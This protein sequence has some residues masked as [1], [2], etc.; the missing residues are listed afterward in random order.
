MDGGTTKT[1]KM[2]PLYFSVLARR[3]TIAGKFQEDSSG[4]VEVLRLPFKRGKSSLM[5]NLTGFFIWL[6]G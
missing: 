4:T 6:Y 3:K 5:R 1:R 2:T